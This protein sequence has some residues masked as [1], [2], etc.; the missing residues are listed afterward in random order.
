M[1]KIMALLLPAIILCSCMKKQYFTDSPEID[2][3]KK[4]DQAFLNRDWETFR[5]HFH[6]TAAIYVNNWFREKL[7]PDQW[8]EMLKSFS[9]DFSSYRYADNTIHEMVIT[10]EGEHWVHGWAEW[11]GVHKSGKEIRIVVHGGWRVESGKIVSAGAIYDTHALHELNTPGPV[12]AT[13]V[14]N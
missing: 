1:K 12:E 4:A 7:T 9:Q 6:D 5:N 10:D 14:Q 11:T 2:L 13:E 8:S 3:I